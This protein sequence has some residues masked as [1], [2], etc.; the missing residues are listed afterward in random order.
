[1]PNCLKRLLS[2]LGEALP[3]IPDHLY[4]YAL[5]GYGDV[6]SVIA[7]WPCEVSHNLYYVKCYRRPDSSGAGLSTRTRSLV[8]P[9][10]PCPM[11]RFRARS[12]FS[13]HPRLAFGTSAL[14]CT[15]ARRATS[16][17]TL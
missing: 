1:M 3:L 11:Q 4:W 2:E 5:F 15:F 6:P 8:I 17:K 9:V 16:P 14:V 12:R 10:P 7:V 13:A